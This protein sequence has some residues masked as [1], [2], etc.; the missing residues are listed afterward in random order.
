MRDPLRCRH[1]S[2][3]A[4][5]KDGKAFGE[6]GAKKNCKGAA[7]GGTDPVNPCTTC[8]A[9][10]H[11]TDLTECADC[12]AGTY[13]IEAV[14]AVGDCTGCAAGTGSPAKSTAADACTAC[15][16]GKY[17]T[18]GSGCIDCAAGKKSDESSTN[19]AACTGESSCVQSTPLQTPY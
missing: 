4:C 19:D 5:L 9:G 13:S 8:E 7:F 16:G 3:H 1:D 15:G 11:T 10:Q 6:Q 18:E 12:A 2:A 14:V 17:S